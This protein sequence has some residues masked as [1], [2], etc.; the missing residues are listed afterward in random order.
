MKK[1]IQSGRK[2]ITLLSV[3][4]ILAVSV[5]SAFIGVDF[6][7]VA[8]TPE[9][10]T[11]I[12][13]GY[14]NEIKSTQF[15]GEGTAVNPYIIKSG[16]Q[17]YK[18][19]STQGKIII[20]EDKNEYG[21][22]AYYK[23][24]DDIY[25][26]DI[27]DYDKWGKKGFD[28]S[29]L[30]NWND[31]S[32]LTN[33]L[34]FEG[35]F[36][37][38]GHTIYGLY[39]E[40]A[41]YAGFIAKVA[42]KATIKNVHF[43]NSYCVNVKLQP[44][45]DR[46]TLTET[47]LNALGDKEGF[48]NNAGA[49]GGHRSWNDANYG[50]ASV[51]VCYVEGVPL[52]ISNCS[53]RDAYVQASS[54]AAAM[55]GVSLSSGSYPSVKNSLVADVTLKTTCKED[56][57]EGVEGAIINTTQGTADSATIEGVISAGV[58]V[59]GADD[60]DTAWN[61]YKIP[62][63][64]SV[65]LFKDVYSDVDH[66]Y[67]IEHSSYGIL[68]FVDQEIQVV[69]PNYLK[70]YKAEE[71]LDLDWEHNWQVVN[72]DYPMP[73]NEYVS[74]TGNEYYETTTPAE[75]DFWDGTTAKNF[76]AGTGT[77]ED[78]YLIENC[79]QFYLMVSTLKA[80]ANYKIAKGVKA[81]YFN[82]VKDLKYTEAMNVLKSKKMYVYAPGETNDFNG[83]FDG[84]GVTIYGIKSQGSVRAG[85]I[86]Q[87]GNATL[88]NFTVKNSWFDANDGY[89]IT[90]TTTEAAAAIAGDLSNGASLS[91]RNVAVIDC[92]VTSVKAAAGM[93]GCS[94]INGSVFIDDSIVADGSIM[95]D[96]G[97]TH[98]AAFVATSKSGSHL[99]KNCISYGI[100]PAA[101]NTNSYLSLFKNV[102]TN[103]EAPS[104][105]VGENAKGVTQVTTEELKGEAVKQTAAAFAWE[106]TWIATNDIPQLSNHV[107]TLG[108][109][110]NAWTGKIAD[111]FAGGNGTMNNP[112]QI[113]TAERLAQMLNYCRDGAYYTLTA[114]IY[115]NDVSNENWTEN[116]KQWFTSNDVYEFTGIFDGN[117]YTIYGLYN[118]DV[119]AGVYA[120]FIPVLGS[121]AELRNVKIDNAYISGQ[122]GSYI[123]AVVG[124][125]QDD[126]SNIVSLRAATVGENV[127]IDGAAN[128]GGVVGRVGF[129]KLRM[130][131]SIFIGKIL[132]TGT[133]AGLVGEVV[134]KLDIK[135]SVSVG[136]APFVSNDRIVCSAIYT[137]ADY[138]AEGVIVLKNSDMIGTNAVESMDALPFGTIWSSTQKYPV[139]THKVQSF[140]GVQGE[141]WSG[142][143]A[144]KFAGGD[145]SK[146]KPYLIA[147]PEQLA[148]LISS[149]AYAEKHFKL[150]ADIYL[151][152][153]SDELWQ[154]KV[155]CNTW[156]N[157]ANFYHA[158]TSHLDGDGYVVFGMYYNYKKTPQNSY[159]GLIPRIGGNSTVKNVGISQAYIK[160]DT[161]D[162]TV[163]AGGIF[164][165]GS[166]FYDFYNQ[167]ISFVAT[168][169]DEFLVPGEAKPRKLPLISNCFVDHT[170]H[171]EATS[172]GGIGC[173]GGA[174]IVIRDCIV[175][176]TVKASESSDTRNA[177]LVSAYWTNASRVYNSVSFTQSKN[178]A[179][180]G[181]QVWARDAGASTIY[182][183]D[184][185]AY[186]DK[187]VLGTTR[188]KRPQWRL[189]EGAKTAMPAL[190]WENVWRTEPEGTP[191]LRIFDKPDRSASQ[192]S[193][194]NFQVDTV[195]INFITGDSSIVVPAIEGKPYE[196]V[197]FP[198][199]TRIGYTFTGWYAFA[200]CSLLYPY[201]YFL[202]RDL[203]VYAG[204]KKNG[205]FQ[206]FENYPYSS[207]DCDNKRWN[208]NK[209]G[210][211]VG[212]QFEYVHTGTKSMQ[213]L[214][215]AATSADLLINYEDWLTIGQ[216]YTMV[217][218]V[219]TDKADTNA[220]LSLVQNNHPDYLDT[221]VSVEPMFTV[222]GQTVGEWKQY[223]YDFTAQTNWVSI[224]ATGNSSL[225]I[226]DVA[227]AVKGTVV[228]SGNDNK[229]NIL[230]GDS[231]GISPST[232]DT[233]TVIALVSVITCAA[234]L[235]IVSKKKHVEV[236]EKN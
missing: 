61:G 46:N 87:A 199:I 13:G 90:K 224:R 150:V 202:G 178:Q 49:T 91:I 148:L 83:Y 72:D 183:Q 86:P 28:M 193:D 164:G 189:G 173:P 50:S 38:D 171:I 45:V 144:V 200:D 218:W 175:T 192:F 221:E 85:I 56:H 60:R 225:F 188:I 114:D 30:N 229:I 17:L 168:E 155:G 217:V 194:K 78:P 27:S 69:K 128:A 113:D 205:V 226:D 81:L 112:Y 196:K 22:P 142:E 120:G 3:L 179:I 2:L 147:T 18:M 57:V 156:F 29:T 236:I 207:Y 73:K 198:E 127:V 33:Q 70:G 106:T 101:D 25:L 107:S 82:N 1:T 223:S 7:A 32:K 134:G 133:T 64:S 40:G 34:K 74:P 136:V 190:D 15:E 220:T 122:A 9:S 138:V 197:T 20:N 76:A 54:F 59:Y 158:F 53:V 131:N 89:D 191:V 209:P 8:D 99:I 6:T 100:Y 21:E 102:Y 170:C 187:T 125:V 215:N 111:V 124:T 160:A 31:V 37:G 167:K 94:G 232:A 214:D 152:D 165:M 98:H 119:A 227:V 47:E 5:F 79:E 75:E 16:D 211:R 44:E 118:K 66:T 65:Y 77:A 180:G 213:L 58:K 80:D 105:V 117:K 4:S 23:L 55:I 141:V 153:V 35:H 184:V 161:N 19:V 41:Y 172:A 203:N 163:Y 97:S 24:A 12:W 143:V 51:V 228:S 68:N 181:S 208:Y 235:M 123:G 210:S 42:G 212:Y 36:D 116:A 177:G 62:T 104:P 216:E 204:W 195:K 151:N 10:T 43:R 48:N 201:E 162:D 39:S 230:N 11:T 140:N 206:D 186:S 92:K 63:V 84:N 67:N 139:P 166:A 182:L 95:S 26:N 115:L 219:A 126:A 88:K 14:F 71:M 149:D 121:G 108:T 185:Y 135:Q 154:A 109:K 110:N 176:A 132:A 157:A 174:A 52:K 129:T 233:T 130:D 93:V 137:D 103:V 145:G 231:N 169:G 159:L 222:S 96:Q 146:L 234:I